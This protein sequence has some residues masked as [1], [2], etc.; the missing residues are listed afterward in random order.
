MITLIIP[1]LN[2]E[3]IIK[4]FCENLESLSKDYKKTFNEEL[5]VIF[6]D[7]GSKDK[8]LKIINEFR[9]AS[10]WKLVSENLDNPT[11]TRTIRTSLNFVSNELIIILPVDCLITKASLMEARGIDNSFFYGAFPKNFTPT[12]W[13]MNQYSHLQNK[14]RLQILKNM[15][16]TNCIVIRKELVEDPMIFQ[17]A[18]FLED[19]ILSDNLKSQYSIH[20]FNNPVF[21]S[22]RKYSPEISFLNS[23][24]QILINFSIILLYR[25]GYK[26][27]HKL[28]KLYNFLS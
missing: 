12:T 10:P 2:E 26:D 16:W 24:V 25:L 3:R 18:E 28:R 23:F 5:E 1:V 17:T 7:P 11:I 15:V 27:L 14:I 20:I 8:T 19:V 6:C 22:S 4:R 21:V 13:F 9:A